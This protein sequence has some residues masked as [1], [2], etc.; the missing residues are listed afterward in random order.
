MIFSDKE[1]QAP[2]ALKDTEPSHL[3]RYLFASSFLTKNDSVL[4]APCGSGYGSKQLASKA[5]KVRGVDIF[6][7]A[8][9]HAK[10]FFSDPKI[11]FIVGDV[12]KLNEIV[13]AK[14]LDV[15]VSFEG[16]EHLHDQVKF[17]SAV[18]ESLKTNGIF[19]VST[20]RKPHGS[21]YHTVEFSQQEFI[22]ILSKKFV[23]EKMFGQIFTDIFDMNERKED[24][25]SHKRFNFIAICRPKEEG[26]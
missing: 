7:G 10:E 16:I 12:E 2:L 23:I 21:P 11:S 24:P 8:I 5:G 20:P 26:K 6:Q 14:S 13:E 3:A 22:D 1:R 19:I 17:L 25:H 9:N 18:K 4:D 15:V